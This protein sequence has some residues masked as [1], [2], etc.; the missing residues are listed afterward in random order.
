MYR[1]Y[2]RVS[3]EQ[4]DERTQLDHILRYLD[5][6]VE[7]IVYKDIKTS[8]KPLQEREGGK[9]LLRDLQRGDTIV[10]IRLDRIARSLSETVLMVERLDKAGA[11]IIL[12]DQPGIKNKIMLGLYAGMAE[13]EVKLLR[14]RISEKLQSKKARNERYT[15]SLPYGFALHETKLVPVKQGKEIVMKRGLL[16]PV[17]EEQQVIKIMVELRE[18][19]RSY[20]EIAKILDELGHKNREDRPFQKMTIKRVVER[21][22][23]IQ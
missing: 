7:Y 17:Y 3:T 5:K 6:D 15:S 22:Q 23:A 10:A 9:A 16:I 2:L 21:C 14:K 20:R 13:E 12:I 11:D 1:I 4:Q 18:E 19:G 8:R